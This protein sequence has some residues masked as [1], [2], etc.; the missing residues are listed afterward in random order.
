MIPDAERSEILNDI[1]GRKAGS[2]LFEGL[3]D[4]TDE[5]SYNEKIPL[6][7]EK[8]KSHAESKEAIDRFCEWLWKYK[9]DVIRHTMLRSVR[10][11]A[12]LGC[13]PDAFYTNTSECINSVIKVRV[14]Y[15][16]NELP[17]FIE[18]YHQL[19]EEQEREVERAVIHRG[20]YRLRPQ[21]RH[22]DVSESKWFQMTREQRTRHLKRVH[23]VL[24][25]DV[26][27]K[28]DV[29]YISD[30]SASSHASTSEEEE[31]SVSSL[32]KQ[33]VS[34]APHLGLPAAAIEAIARKA[35]EIL[36]VEGAIVP[37]PGHDSTARMVISKSGKRPHLVLPKKNGGMACDEDCPQYKSAG[38][39]SHIIAAAQHNHQLTELVSSYQK[40]KRTP[41]LTKLA[42]SEMPKGRGRK[43]G[44]GPTKRKP[45]VPVESRYELNVPHSV[46]SSS[47]ITVTSCP[48]TVNACTANASMVHAAPIDTCIS[49]Y[50]PFRPSPPFQPSSPFQP[51]PLPVQS[52]DWNPNYFGQHPFHICFVAGNISVCNGC[53]GRYYKEAG[54]PHD[55]CVQHE[56]W[57]T[58]TLSGSAIPQSRFGNVYYHCSVNCISA[59]W[60]SFFPSL[61]IVPPHMHAKLDHVHKQWISSQFGIVIP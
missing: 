35:S 58:F 29:A 32:S 28:D 23:R 12:G 4:S 39:C 37:A 15:K 44:K 26:M 9:V 20:K 10:E 53:K 59:V 5:A 49:P 31:V 24:L 33:L 25:S 1:F 48:L 47:T 2:T 56:E 46:S 57:R 7:M 3:V 17:Q 61:V 19:C 36:K 52:Y 50:P 43:G 27:K 16:R 34:I 51:S 40:V 8:W 60:P 14:E 11:E 30:I 21:Y 18:K 22:L 13:P 54:P 42:T 38:L 6:I 55:L 45:S 41:N